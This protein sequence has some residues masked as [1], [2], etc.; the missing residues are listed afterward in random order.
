MQKLPLYGEVGGVGLG[1]RRLERNRLIDG[2]GSKKVE[3]GPGGTKK[4]QGM[5]SLR[6]SCPGLVLDLVCPQDDGFF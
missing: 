3:E 6:T 2:S 4:S 1:L 5:G